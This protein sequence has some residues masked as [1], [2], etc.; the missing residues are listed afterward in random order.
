VECDG[1]TEDVR[2]NRRYRRKTGGIG[3]DRERCRKIRKYRPFETLR[4]R[5]LTKKLF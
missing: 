3:R 2:I 5:K 4:H 1:K